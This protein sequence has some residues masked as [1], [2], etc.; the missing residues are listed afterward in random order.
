MPTHVDLFDLYTHALTTVSRC[1]EGTD[2]PD[3]LHISASIQPRSWTPD[4][5]PKGPLVPSVMVLYKHAPTSAHAH[6]TRRIAHQDTRHVVQESV[7]PFLTALQASAPVLQGPASAMTLAWT[8]TNT[9]PLTT[10]ADPLRLHTPQMHVN[11]LRVDHEHMLLQQP[12]APPFSGLTAALHAVQGCRPASHAYQA[13]IQGPPCAH[14]PASTVT[15][16]TVE[17]AQR[18]AQAMRPRVHHDLPIL[19]TPWSELS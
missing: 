15:A 8:I 2:Q 1:I 16:A 4:G 10:K 6:I 13:H 17:D 19:I 7:L 18:F 9:P 11:L 5:I 12:D 3:L 14:I